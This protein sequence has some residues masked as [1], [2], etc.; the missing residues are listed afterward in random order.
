[1]NKNHT[2]CPSF[3]IL[4]KLFKSKGGMLFEIVAMPILRVVR[5]ANNSGV[6]VVSHTYNYVILCC[7]QIIFYGQRG[8]TYYDWQPTCKCVGVDSFILGTMPIYN[9]DLVRG[10]G[11]GHWTNK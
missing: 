7:T 8:S 3:F 2:K 11:M 5:F 1:M 6:F 4:R 9:F 10:H